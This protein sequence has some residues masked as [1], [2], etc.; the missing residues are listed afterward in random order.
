MQIHNGHTRPR[1]GQ[2][3]LTVIVPCYNEAATIGELL[4]RVVAA[5][6]T[7]QIVVVDDGSTDGSSEILAGWRGRD[8]V[9]L[10][11]HDHNCGKGAAVRT[12]IKLAL[13]KYSIIQDADLETD[14]E[15][16]AALLAPLLRGDADIVIGSR[17]LAGIRDVTSDRRFGAWVSDC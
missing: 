7:K 12:A 16:Y 13:G 17:Y 8:G 11:R 9:E 15:D 4:R 6:F 5:P 10:V 2:P 3:T 14:P 1:G